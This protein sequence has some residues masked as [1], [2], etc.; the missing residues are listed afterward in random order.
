MGQRINIQY[1]IDVDDLGDEVER[2]LQK[3]F[4]ELSKLSNTRI[5]NSLSLEAIEDIDAV[6]QGLAAIDATLQDVAAIVNG[7]VVYKTS[8][9]SSESIIEQKEKMVQQ[10]EESSKIEYS[11]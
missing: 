5:T 7:Y 8:S 9:N 1:S 11:F 6:R 2:L 10:H 3:S 4:G